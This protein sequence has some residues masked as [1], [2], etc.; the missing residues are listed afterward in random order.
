M[1]LN[2]QKTKDFNFTISKESAKVSDILRDIVKHNEDK[3]I[4]IP[5]IYEGK[6]CK[7]AFEFC[8][9][10]SRNPYPDIT[11]PLDDQ[12]ELPNFYNEVLHDLNPVSVILLL[13]LSDYLLIT[14][15]NKL[16]CLHLAY[17]MRDMENHQRLNYFNIGDSMDMESAEM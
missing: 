16:I 7:R 12:K 17:L 9:F 8:E 10:Y 3:I 14:P 2:Q 13:V 5:F 15:L 4:D 11:H 1:S 6:L